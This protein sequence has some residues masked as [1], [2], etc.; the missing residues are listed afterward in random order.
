MKSFCI[1]FLSTKF[2]FSH[3]VLY[4]E[5]LHSTFIYVY[6]CILSLSL[7]LSLSLK[8]WKKGNQ[9]K[10]LR[11]RPHLENTANLRAFSFQKFQWNIKSIFLF[12]SCDWKKFFDS[13]IYD[14]K[15]KE[16]KRRE[17]MRGRKSKSKIKFLK[18]QTLYSS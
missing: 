9:M 17:E 11:C 2:S 1:T 16:K 7:S 5:Y 4:V 14:E 6:P 10:L 8:P 12:L 18:I 3:T 13:A 15:R